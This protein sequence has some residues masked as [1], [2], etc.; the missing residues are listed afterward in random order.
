M[1]DSQLY[2]PLY[3]PWEGE[4]A[5]EGI[6]RQLQSLTLVSRERCYILWKTLQQS[7]HLQ[8]DFVECGVFR[9]GTALLAAQ[10]LREHMPKD[11][12]FIYLIVLKACPRPPVALTVS[13]RVIFR[14]FGRGGG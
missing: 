7:V 5:F 10:T 1:P 4:Q 2:Q 14:D 3:S 8:G 12:S 9:G 11:V 6:Y 13:D